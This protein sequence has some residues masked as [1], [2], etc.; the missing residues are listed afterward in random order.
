[1][2]TPILPPTPDASSDWHAWD[3]YLRAVQIANAVEA[4]ATRSKMADAQA[5]TARAMSE[6]TLAMSAPG[7]KPSRGEMVTRLLPGWPHLRSDTEAS[8]V[9]DIRKSVDAIASAY[10]GLFRD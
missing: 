5:D 6:A 1:V 7:P 9:A 3:V 4:E 2:I 8:V 10:P